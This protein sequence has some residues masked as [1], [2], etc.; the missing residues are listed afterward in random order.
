MSHFFDYDPDDID[1]QFAELLT[2]T[3]DSV[4]PLVHPKVSEALGLMRRH[5][6]M[7]VMFV[8][9][10]RDRKRTFRVVDASPGLTKV[11]AGHSD[12]LEES[13]CHFVVEGRAPQLITDPA[14]LVEAGTL[15]EPDLP[16]GTHLSTPIRLKN[17]TVYGTLCCFSE[18]VKQGVSGTQLRRLQA[19]AKILGEDLSRTPLGAELELSP[20]EPPARTR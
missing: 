6:G 18:E 7:D 1:V 12:P 20:L 9:Q 8:S 10:F 16:I 14:P 15:P 5:L 3:H 2:A 4:D 19:A 13:W 11:V 17:G